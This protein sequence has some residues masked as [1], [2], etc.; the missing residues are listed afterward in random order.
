ML[1]EIRCL[2][3][4]LGVAASLL[5]A[6]LLTAFVFLVIDAYLYDTFIAEGTGVTARE[7]AFYSW[8]S[9]LSHLS[10]LI[11]AFFL[12][13]VL[14]GRIV[15]A[16]PE[17]NGAMSAATATLIGFVL[18]VGPVVRWIWEPISNPGEAYTRSDNL[19]TLVFLALVFC[20]LLPFITLAGCLGGWLGGRLRN[21]GTTRVE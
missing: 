1:R 15:L 20:V 19:N 17:L 7:D 18:L 2:G 11:L 4:I 10:A 13:S 21:K 14:V 6:Y 5:L 12:S 16:S 9:N 8:L 3:V